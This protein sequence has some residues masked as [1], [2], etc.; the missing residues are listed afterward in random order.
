MKSKGEAPKNCQGCSHWKEARQKLR[1]NES[2]E[3]TI[4]EMEKRLRGGELKPTLGDYL[5]LLQIGKEFEDDAPK[6]IRVTW[7]EPEGRSGTE[8]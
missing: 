7:V 4:A 2:I 1:I 3:K 6:E 8:E 5:K